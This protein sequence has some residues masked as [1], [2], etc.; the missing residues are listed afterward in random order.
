MSPFDALPFVTAIIVAVGGLSLASYSGQ[1][2]E[3]GLTIFCLAT[4]YGFWSEKRYFDKRER[5]KMERE[6]PNAEKKTQPMPA[7][8]DLWK[9][10]TERW[11]FVAFGVSVAM[12]AFPI[13]RLYLV[14]TCLEPSKCGPEYLGFWTKI[15]FFVWAVGV[16]IYFFCEWYFGIDWE[17]AMLPENKAALDALKSYQDQA[18]AVWAGFAAILGAF[19]LKYG[20]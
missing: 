11:I 6:M 17:R 15:V 14:F 18:R 8:R 3:I 2:Y 16:P 10:G 20:G 12:L 1:T 13:S 5:R 4:G 7:P 9:S 19:L